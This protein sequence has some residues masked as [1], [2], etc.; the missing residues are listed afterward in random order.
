MIADKRFAG[1]D[2]EMLGNAT[3]QLFSH[4]P[5]VVEKGLNKIIQFPPL[6][7][8]GKGPPLKQGDAEEFLQLDHLAAYGGLLDAIR[9]VAHGFG[10]AAVARHIIKKLEV[11]NVH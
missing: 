6:R 8:E 2:A 9:H 7:R 3:L 1:R 10:N 11:V 5:E 4:R